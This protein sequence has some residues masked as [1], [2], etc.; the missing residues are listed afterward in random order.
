[1]FPSWLSLWESDEQPYIIHSSSP[2]LLVALETFTWLVEE[3]CSVSG[4]T[5]FSFASRTPTTCLSA[6]FI[7]CALHNIFS[8]TKVLLAAR[9]FPCV[10]FFQ[11]PC[12]MTLS[13]SLIYSKHPAAFPKLSVSTGSSFVPGEVSADRAAIRSLACASLK[14]CRTPYF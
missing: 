1:M 5:F 3:L 13:L 12:A 14:P 8:H 11:L 2:S 10:H 7:E 9:R 6:S 4:E